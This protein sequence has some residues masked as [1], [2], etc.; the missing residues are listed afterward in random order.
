MHLALK[1]R[2]V[3][4]DYGN[5][6]SN[7][8]QHIDLSCVGGT[9]AYP[10][11]TVQKEKVLELWECQENHHSHYPLSCEVKRWNDIY[12]ALRA[13]GETRAVVFYL[14][15]PDAY[16]VCG[17][18]KKRTFTARMDQIVDISRANEEP[19]LL[20]TLFFAYYPVGRF[21][22]KKYL[23]PVILDDPDFPDE[24]KKCVRC[25]Y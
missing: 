8:N 17:E 6:G 24:L 21:K 25:V 4:L 18:K 5:S 7:P 13:S 16:T 9:R 12:S 3:V 1:E 2:K 11:F 20:F 10:D 15:N 23:F 14:V 22:G 19:E